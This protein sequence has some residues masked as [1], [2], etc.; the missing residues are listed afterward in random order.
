MNPIHYHTTTTPYNSPLQPSPARPVTVV[1]TQF[2]V[3]VDLEDENGMEIED[4]NT[5]NPMAQSTPPVQIPQR[6]HL[7][8]WPNQHFSD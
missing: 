4:E 5:P 2:E 1:I 3:D 6:T 7:Q 8:E